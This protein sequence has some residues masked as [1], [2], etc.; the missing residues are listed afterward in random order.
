MK[1][2]CYLHALSSYVPAEVLTNDDLSKLVEINDEWINTRTGNKRCLRLP[3]AD[4]A[5]DLGTL[6]LL[7]LCRCR[8]RV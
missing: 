2:N 4:N 1:P 5:F 8:R 6:S 7:N 3:Q